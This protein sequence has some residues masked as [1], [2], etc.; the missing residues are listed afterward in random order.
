MRPLSFPSCFVVL[1]LV[2]QE[3]AHVGA[4][5]VKA[6]GAV[7]FQN[8]CATCHGP[9]GQGSEALKAPP[10][11]GLPAWYGLRQVNN[12]REGG[13]GT[14]AKEPQA[15]IMAAMVKALAPAQ[16][17]QVTAFVETLPPPTLSSSG[18][19]NANLALGKELFEERCME[20][21]RYNASGEMTF[22]SPPLVGL[23]DWYLLAQISKFKTGER[24]PVP[25]D[26][27]G[28][29]MVFASQF[30]ETE[31]AMRGVA[32]YILTLNAAPKAAE[33]VEALFQ[34]VTPKR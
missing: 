22:G 24:A 27:Y 33:N 25:G 23:P 30:M 8:V 31:E 11:A 15:M 4:E 29:K 13:R 26:P 32:A 9:T 10:I 7:L 1:L 16:L 3:V 6:A 5:E 34:V 18:L 19:K 17:E 28:A 2:V 21:H 20:C 12:F 14:S